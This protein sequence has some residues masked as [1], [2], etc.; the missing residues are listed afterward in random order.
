MCPTT[1]RNYL[2][3]EQLAAA[4]LAPQGKWPW[5]GDK[6]R[7]HRR[8]SSFLMI[9][10]RPWR[11]LHSN[12]LKGIHI[13]A[14]TWALITRPQSDAAFKIKPGRTDETCPIIT[15]IIDGGERSEHSTFW[16][17]EKAKE[18]H[19]WVSLQCYPPPP[20][21]REHYLISADMFFASGESLFLTHHLPLTLA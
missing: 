2:N 12:A 14:I 4:Q 7:K 1:D 3:A 20:M 9:N 10:E 13:T 16:F 11:L 21:M 17:C 18:T 8:A 5:L 6:D 15:F 19:S